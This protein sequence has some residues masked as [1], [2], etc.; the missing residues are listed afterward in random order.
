MA[1]P[2]DVDTV[3]MG[4]RSLASY[5]EPFMQRLRVRFPRI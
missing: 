1:L 2:S 5:L 4:G 3:E